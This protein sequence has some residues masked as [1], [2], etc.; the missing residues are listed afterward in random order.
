MISAQN[1]MWVVNNNSIDFDDIKQ[2]I[3]TSNNT[4]HNF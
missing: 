1:E 4:N 2:F 3:T